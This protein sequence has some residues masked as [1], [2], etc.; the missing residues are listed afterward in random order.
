MAGILPSNGVPPGSTEGGISNPQLAA[1]CPNTYY[2]PRCNPRLDPFAMNNLI[3]EVVNALNVLGEVYNCNVNN[4]L[5]Q[6]LLDLVSNQYNFGIA[7]G[8]A[9]AKTLTLSPDFATYHPGMEVAFRSNSTNTG[10]MTLNVNGLGVRNI[11]SPS[12]NPMAAGDVPGGSI[13]QLIY[14]GT[15]WIAYTKTEVVVPPAPPSIGVGQSL[16][17]HQE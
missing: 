14:D 7:A 11:V 12:G 16:R 9:N 4:N 1:G 15:N 8:S 13:L 2:P 17:A 5:A 6:S 10:P 3:S